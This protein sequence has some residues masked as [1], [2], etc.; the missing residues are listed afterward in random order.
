MNSSILEATATVHERIDQL[1][2]TAHEKGYSFNNDEFNCIL[3][4]DR[5][6]QHEINDVHLNFLEQMKDRIL[7]SAEQ[8]EQIKA[9]QDK[10][11]ELSEL[12]KKISNAV[13]V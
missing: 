5:I 8:A 6:P 13:R 7:K 12:Q 3:S 1:F 2:T 9:Q 4:I 10:E 11:K